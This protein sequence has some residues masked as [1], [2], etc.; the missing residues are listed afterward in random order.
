M[1][2]KYISNYI[3]HESAK[4]TNSVLCVDNGGISISKFDVETAFTEYVDGAIAIVPGTCVSKT[5]EIIR[6]ST[7]LSTAIDK[8]IAM[9]IE[10]ATNSD[11]VIAQ[12]VFPQKIV[13]ILQYLH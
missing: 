12:I 10:S 3:I 1:I 9:E 13:R 4:H 8:I 2:R 7:D 11:K 5:E 6:E